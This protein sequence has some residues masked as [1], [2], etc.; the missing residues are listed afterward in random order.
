MERQS[1]SASRG[2]QWESTCYDLAV[3][4]T[5]LKP[6][7]VLLPLTTRSGVGP[8]Q[9]VTVIVRRSTEILGLLSLPR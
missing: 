5:N 2:F 6:Q 1:K 3:L 8:K 7:G 4:L 9:Y